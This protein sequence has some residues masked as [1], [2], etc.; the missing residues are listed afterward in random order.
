MTHFLTPTDRG[1]YCPAAD[2]YIDPWRPVPRAVITHAHSDH[3]KPG[4]TSYLTAEPGLHV[5][6]H[7]LGERAHIDTLPYG[8]S[9]DVRGVTISLHPAGHVLGSA[10]VRLEHR[11]V[12]WVVSGDYKLQPDPTCEP[13]QP[14]PCDVFVTESTFGLPVYRW[15]DPDSVFADI[16]AWWRDNQQQG[17]TSV[18]YAYSLGK[19]QRILRGIDPSIGPILAHG[20]IANML[21]AY[22]ASGVGLPT[23]L[24]ADADTR[25]AHRSRALV[26][27][28]PS[29]ASSP[30]LAKF[31]PLSDAMA[32]GWARIRGT[33]RRRAIDRGFVISDHAD[34]PGLLSAVRATGAR[35]I[36]VTHGYVNP[37]VRYL[38]QQGLEAF[39]VPT[40]F[41]GE[42]DEAVN[43]EP[44]PEPTSDPNPDTS[45]E[46]GP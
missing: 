21:P 35:S 37:F 14:L 1:L 38:R 30:W 24:R 32:S 29:A 13:F 41:T 36:G 40:R 7:R 46:P 39:E 31:E 6:R 5:L 43:P 33:R 26:L 17:R 45:P 22:E 11:G 28:P 44:G 20:A 10:Q 16:N 34:W 18:I 23:V 25:R 8:R 9:I 3:A 42:T 15:P 2:L 12:V 27:A 4:C 19:A